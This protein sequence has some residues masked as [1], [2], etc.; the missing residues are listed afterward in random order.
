MCLWQQLN[1]CPQSL[2]LEV[3]HNIYPSILRVVY[4]MATIFWYCCGHSFGDQHMPMIT[5]AKKKPILYIIL[6]KC[7]GHQFSI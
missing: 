7:Y 2:G 5:H 1:V 6:L 4:I 3:K